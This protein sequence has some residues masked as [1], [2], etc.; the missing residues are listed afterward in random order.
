MRHFFS[1][2]GMV[3]G[4]V[5]LIATE[6]VHAQ[7]GPKGE[8]K[9]DVR[10]ELMNKLMQKRK[11]LGRLREILKAEPTAKEV[12]NASLQF[13]RLEPERIVRMARASNLKALIP[14]IEASLDHTVGSTFTNT[15]DGLYPVLASPP[16]NP[17]PFNYK[18]RVQ[19]TSDQFLWRFRAVWNFDRLLFNSEE[20]DVKSLASIEE[21]LVREVTTL[22]YARRRLLASLILS[23]PDDEEEVFYEQLRLDEMTSTLDALTGG[24]F[25]PRAWKNDLAP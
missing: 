17:N 18:E 13:Y 25:G 19:G 1:T 9:T 16:E 10:E 24:M 20:L 23:P 21:N 4:F 22:F 3:L 2:F 7:A 8:G 14:E 11:G 15:K 12:Q 6:S 5:T